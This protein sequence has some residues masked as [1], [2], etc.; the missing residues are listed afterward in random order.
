MQERGGGEQA[1]Q[2]Q[3]GHPEQRQ[4]QQPWPPGLLDLAIGAHRVRE[5]RREPGAEPRHPFRAEDQPGDRDRGQCGRHHGDRAVDG[6]PG[7]AQG[8]LVP[9]QPLPAA[10]E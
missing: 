10:G 6:Q 2:H 7:G 1:G 5:R 9:G 4:G 3:R 8:D